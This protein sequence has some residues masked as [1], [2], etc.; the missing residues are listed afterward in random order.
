MSFITDFDAIVDYPGLSPAELGF[1]MYFFRNQGESFVFYVRNIKKKF[2]IKDT[3]YSNVIHSL[4]DK[5]LISYDQMNKG[6]FGG[7]QIKIN[8]SRI[9]SGEQV[10]IS[11]TGKSVHGKSEY[12]KTAYGKTVHGESET[13]ISVHGKSCHINEVNIEGSKSSKGVNQKGNKSSKGVNLVR[14]G[15]S[16][17][18]APSD[19][20]PAPE[21][22][23]GTQTLLLPPDIPPAPVPDVNLSEIPNSS[24]PEKASTKFIPPT[25]AEVRAELESLLAKKGTIQRWT[26]SDMQT[27]TDRFYDWYDSAHWLKN[28]GRKMKDWQRALS[29]TWLAKREYLPERQLQTL[30]PSQSPAPQRQPPKSFKQQDLDYANRRFNDPVGEA[31]RAAVDACLGMG[32]DDPCE[33]GL[34]EQYREPAVKLLQEERKRLSQS[35]NPFPAIPM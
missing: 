18:A 30:P 4:Q 16:V 6:K 2:S 28:D 32:G 14:E 25:K 5:D 35:F 7:I 31:I 33:Y 13:G 21:I 12:G 15:D 8:M 20:F 3:A 11:E 29:C 34:P 26:D 9:R 19:T 27:M 10:T 22:P 24:A 1:L 23:A 17:P